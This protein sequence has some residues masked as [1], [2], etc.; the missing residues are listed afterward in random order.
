MQASLRSI[1]GS[2]VHHVVS[3]AYS[4]AQK[5]LSLCII[6]VTFIVS[7]WEF[8]ICFRAKLSKGVGPIS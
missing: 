8:L 7:I 6:K 5:D 4:A 2:W 1:L 3:L